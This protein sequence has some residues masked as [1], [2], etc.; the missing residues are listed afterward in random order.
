MST[1]PMTLPAHNLRTQP[2]GSKLHLLT[3]AGM[4]AGSAAEG[5]LR[6]HAAAADARDAAAVHA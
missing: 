5:L 1:K 3:A 6:G 4:C 2:A